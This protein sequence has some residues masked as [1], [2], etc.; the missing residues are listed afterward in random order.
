MQFLFL[1][2]SRP[3]K[4]HLQKR[5]Y[6]CCG[7]WIK[8]SELSIFYCTFHISREWGGD[9]Q[10]EKLCNNNNNEK[11]EG[12]KRQWE[13]F[14][15]LNWA[16]KQY[17]RKCALNHKCNAQRIL[18]IKMLLAHIFTIHSRTQP[19]ATFRACLTGWAESSNC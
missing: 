1:V 8:K 14:K 19:F 9:V 6:G 5:R 16:L 4:I 12:M 18:I 15:A 3:L 11:V 7:C 10:R 2:N 17:R 13:I